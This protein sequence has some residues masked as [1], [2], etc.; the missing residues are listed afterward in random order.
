MNQKTHVPWLRAPLT[1]LAILLFALLALL[2][3]AVIQ[4]QVAPATTAAVSGEVSE[5]VVRGKSLE[6]RYRNT[7]APATD[8][9]G[10]V[11]VRDGD[12]TLIAAVPLVDGRRVKAG[13]LET[14]RVAMPALPPGKY[15]IYAVI[16]FGGESL[17]AA[18]ADLEIQP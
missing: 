1:A 11:Q 17:T 15:T 6:V 9:V 3:A 7:G 4:A 10:E 18:Q 14:F 13:K 2:P 16:D 8:I 5:M 12:D